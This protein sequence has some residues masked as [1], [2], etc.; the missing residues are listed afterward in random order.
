[1]PN[2]PTGY[3][4]DKRT[5]ACTALELGDAYLFAWRKS[6]RHSDLRAVSIFS[7]ILIVMLDSVYIF[8]APYLWNGILTGVV[9]YLCLYLIEESRPLPTLPDRFPQKT[10]FW[11]GLS[12]A[13][14]LIAP[15]ICILFHRGMQAIAR[16]QGYY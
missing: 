5:P 15:I 11:P 9:T 10:L 14:A 12:Y 16:S 4:V 2:H 8:A 6:R 3:K 7:G 1:M 13:A